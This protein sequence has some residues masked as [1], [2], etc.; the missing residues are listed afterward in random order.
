MFGPIDSTILPLVKS[1]KD[2]EL[3]CWKTFHLCLRLKE[4]QLIRSNAIHSS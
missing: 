3:Y 1:I 2:N 4:A